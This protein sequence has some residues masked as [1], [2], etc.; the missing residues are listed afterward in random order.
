M[1]MVTYDFRLTS[2]RNR[3]SRACRHADELREVL[4]AVNGNLPE[5]DTGANPD[6][7]ARRSLLD[8]VRFRS[9]RQ[10]L[11]GVAIGLMLAAFGGL[12]TELVIAWLQAR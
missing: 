9:A 8:F 1:V 5:P 2:G 10:W 11:L 7:Q 6:R 4:D 3:V 12:S